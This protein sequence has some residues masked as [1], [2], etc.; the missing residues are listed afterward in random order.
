MVAPSAAELKEVALTL[1]ASASHTFKSTKR[2]KD[3]AGEHVWKVEMQTNA[4]HNGELEV[5]ERISIRVPLWEGAEPIILD[6]RFRIRIRD[7]AA[8]FIL[9]PDDWE[10]L[11]QDAW[12]RVCETIATELEVAVYQQ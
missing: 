2:L 4:G 11:E 8:V 12:R 10:G 7:G 6:L 5:P 1:E 9:L 3:G